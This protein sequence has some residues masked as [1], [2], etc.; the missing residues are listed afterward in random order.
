[1]N[2]VACTKR[3]TNLGINS[4]DIARLFADS[5]QVGVNANRAFGARI[6]SP[7]AT[8]LHG[9]FEMSIRFSRRAIGGL[10]V[11]AVLLMAGRCFATYF[12]L[13]PSKDEWGLKYDVE[14]TATDGDKLNILF[15]LADEGRLK[16]IHSAT[17]VAFSNPGYDGGRSYLANA[18]LVLKPNKQGKLAG[19]T[20]ISKE[21]MDRAQIRILTLSVDGK[22]QTAGAASYYISLKR[23]LNKTPVA[24]SASAPVSLPSPPTAKVQN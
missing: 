14:V 3:V 21:V 17:L 1:M 15:T 4:I 16:P 20:Q 9:E 7:S 23:F 8:C 24:A 5:F 10:V 12:P 13:G 2:G 11:A 6:G 19:Q 22:R 18:P